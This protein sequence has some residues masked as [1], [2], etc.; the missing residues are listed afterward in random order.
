MPINKRDIIRIA[1]LLPAYRNH[2]PPTAYEQFLTKLGQILLESN[3]EFD[4][5][6]FKAYAYDNGKVILKK[7]RANAE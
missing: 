5:A 6:I 2:F 7:E 4:L 1:R 3:P